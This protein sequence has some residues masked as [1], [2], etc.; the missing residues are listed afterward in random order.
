MQKWP[1]WPALTVVCLHSTYFDYSHRFYLEIWQIAVQFSCKSEDVVSALK[2]QAIC[3]A[4]R[5]L[6]HLTK[7]YVSYIEASPMIGGAT[8]FRNDRYYV[9]GM[10]LWS[11]A[12]QGRLEAS[13]G[14]R[15]HEP[16]VLH[17]L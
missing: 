16:R 1:E 17:S 4:F 12:I 6:L 3:V 7:G 8:I 13:P 2:C 14:G 15:C 11:A 10:N 9:V 5:D